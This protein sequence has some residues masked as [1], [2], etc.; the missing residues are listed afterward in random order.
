[1]Q[2]PITMFDKFAL[3]RAS[4]DECLRFARQLLH[5]GPGQNRTADASLFR[6]SYRVGQVA[7]NQRKSLSTVRLCHMRFRTG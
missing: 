4:L 1:M 5:V 7:R 3:E 2:G 6:A